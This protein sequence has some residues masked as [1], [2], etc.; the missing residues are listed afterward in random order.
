MHRMFM[1]GYN[2]WAEKAVDGWMDKHNIAYD[3]STQ[4]QRKGKG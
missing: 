2:Q 4:R 1:K 3:D